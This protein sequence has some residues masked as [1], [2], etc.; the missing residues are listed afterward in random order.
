V[1]LADC[2]KENTIGSAAPHHGQSFQVSRSDPNLF[3]FIMDPN[4]FFDD[5]KEETN[6]IIV[7]T[8]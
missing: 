5:R 8:S 2:L 4:L 1:S 6:F 3:F 7:E